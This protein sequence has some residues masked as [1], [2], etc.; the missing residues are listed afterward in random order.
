VIKNDIKISSAIVSLF[1]ELQ[2]TP[3]KFNDILI[4]IVLKYECAFML[5]SNDQI[6]RKP[7]SQFLKRYPLE[8]LQYLIKSERI[9]DSYTFKFLF[10]LNKTELAFLNV[11]KNEPYRIINLLNGDL[12]IQQTQTNS[13]IPS[14]STTVTAKS[15]HEYNFLV[16]TSS[17]S[18][19]S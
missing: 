11:F 5:D 19:A 7:L 16:F 13:T 2:L 3:V 10:Y 14:T 9:K 4:Q 18:L 8:T 12:T 17:A 1:A 15:Y 6:F